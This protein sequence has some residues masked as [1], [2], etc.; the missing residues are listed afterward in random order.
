[1]PLPNYPFKGPIMDHYT[2]YAS[3]QEKEDSWGDIIFQYER[4]REQVIELWAQCLVVNQENTKPWQSRYEEILIL[5][6]GRSLNGLLN[7]DEIPISDHD[8]YQQELEDMK[9]VAQ[10]I[11]DARVLGRQEA[12]RQ[13]QEAERLKQQ[14]DNEDM[15]RRMYET[16]KKKFEP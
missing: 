13:R 6:N 15:Q 11:A 3:K 7:D 12:S 8:D 5:K 9:A 14:K 10:S 16:L 2:F 4:N 1:M